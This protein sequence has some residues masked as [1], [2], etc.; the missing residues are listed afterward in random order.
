[1][2]QSGAAR[3]KMKEKLTAEVKYSEATLREDGE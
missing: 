2:T 1:V 3:L